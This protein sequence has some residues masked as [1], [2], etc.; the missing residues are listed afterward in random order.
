MGR[1]SG[2]DDS[3]WLREDSDPRRI[4]D[5]ENARKNRQEILQQWSWGKISRR[6]M[7]KWGLFTSAGILAPIGG[8]SPFARAQTASSSSNNNNNNC[9]YQSFGDGGGGTNNNG[10]PTGLPASPT[11]GVAP[12]SQP[13]LRFDVLGLNTRADGSQMTPFTTGIM[14]P[15]PSTGS[16]PGPDPQLSSNQTQQV[17]ASALQ[18]SGQTNA[19][20]PIEGRPPGAEWAHQL[21]FPNNSFFSQ[22]A[23]KCELTTA[24]CT[25]N[26]SYDPAVPAVENNGVGKGTTIPPSFAPFTSAFPTQQSQQLWTWNGTLPPKLMQSRYGY[27]VL[28]R[29]HNAL[30]TN[31]TNNGGFGRFTLTT[32]EHNAHH[33]AENDG[34]TGAYFWPNQ[35]Y[36]YFYP[37]TLAGWRSINTGA[38]NPAAGGPNNNGGATLVAGDPLETMSSHW[39]HDHMFTFTDQNVYKGIAGMN[40]IYSLYDRGNETH[41]D[42][43]NFQLPS[44]TAND[45][46]NLDFDVNLLVADKAWTSTGQLN[47]DVLAFDGFLGDQVLTNFCWKPYFNVYARRY[48]FRILNASVSR[49]FAFALS[50]GSGFV[51]IANDGNLLPQT[52]PLTQTDYL[53]IAERYDIVI[54]FS[55]YSAGQTVQLVNL[56]EHQNGEEPLQI[57]TLA[58]ALSSN[59]CDPGVGPFLQFNIVGP[60]PG[61]DPSTNPLGTGKGIPLIQNP[62]LPATTRERQF[63]FDHNAQQT[64]DDPITTYAGSGKWGIAAQNGGGTRSSS[65]QRGGSALK[66]DFGRV[67]SQPGYGTLEVWTLVNGGK[68][69]DH[70]I[71]IHFEEGRILARNG[72]ASNV[73]ATEQGRKDVYRLGAGGS[74]TVALQFR[75]W[76]GM[77]MEHC[78]NTMH[79][80]NAML[81]RWDINNA[82]EPFVNPLPTPIPKVTG[83]TFEPP[84]QILT[85]A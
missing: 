22:I 65:R 3:F 37:W 10:I 60:A 58:E 72:S 7:V 62:T 79:E 17:L 82:G 51:Q 45:F 69:W 25:S 4:R 9:S 43:I 31:I 85:N 41:D 46:G 47:M 34:F 78:H 27:P 26:T 39:F 55:R 67:S 24:P 63:V 40:N 52:V 21:Q 1:K 12:F 81:L 15:I 18:P 29:Q 6:D 8:L 54:D 59:H 64:T 84:D 74:V 11:F 77:F 57:L 71:H 49:F 48:R 33:G 5:A 61:G 76:G 75:D 19:T 53:G 44:G 20:G 42:G 83:V 50:D 38:T 80:D 36:D 23:Y 73:E 16:S 70:P 2:R 13:M 28:F 68:N 56:A 30:T 66:A 35:F 14:Q 32:H